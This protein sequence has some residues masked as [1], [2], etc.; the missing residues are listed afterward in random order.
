MTL[1]FHPRIQNDLLEILD[2]Y[3]RRSRIAG[4]RFF[5][6][7]NLAGFNSPKLASA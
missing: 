1:I 2:Y 7:F 4:D 3:D 6:E 5:D